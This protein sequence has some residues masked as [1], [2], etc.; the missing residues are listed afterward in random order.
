[1]PTFMQRKSS[2]PLSSYQGNRLLALDIFRGITMAAMILVNDPGISNHVYAPLEHAAWNGITP[3][4]FI[5]P[6]FIFIVGVSVVLSCSN[7]LQKE[8]PKKLMVRKIC[9]RAL[10][11][12][13]LGLFLSILPS[14]KLSNIRFPGVLQRISIVY[15]SCALLY[16][17]TS[18]TFQIRL[19]IFILV[20]YF[21]IMT[22]V[23]VPGYGYPI[24][25]PGKNLAAWVD[26]MVMPGRMYQ[27]TWDPEGVLSSFQAIVTGIAGMLAGHLIISNKTADRKIIWLFLAGF[28]SFT[29]ANAWNW[30]FPINKNLWTSSFVLFVGGLDCMILASLYFLTDV[31][32]IR[33]WATFA[34]VFG[35]NAMAAYL[36]SE[37]FYNIIYFKY[38]GVNSKSLNAVIINAVIPSGIS[39]ELISLIWAILYCILCYVP[40]Y[41]LYKKKI[42][43]KI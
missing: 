15:F 18:I 24:L 17:F 38:G 3:T 22:L 30:F 8:I 13:L 26:S 41:I 2:T 31:S 5:F 27:G 34:L 6:S 35:S 36:V 7:Q 20:T 12:F 42:F 14:F 40:L 33:K 28:I 19:A 4:D 39:P 23:P 43:L 9:K 10:I 1:M 32:G 21:L 16:L 25:E 29:I 37:F 11:L